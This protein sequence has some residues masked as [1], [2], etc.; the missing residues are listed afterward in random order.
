MADKI[1]DHGQACEHRSPTL[2]SDAPKSWL[3]FDKF[4]LH[5]KCYGPSDQLLRRDLWR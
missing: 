2:Y 5:K 3:R 1:A 4:L